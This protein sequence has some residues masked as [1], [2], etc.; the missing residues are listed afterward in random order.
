MLLA[1][2]FGVSRKGVS[3]AGHAPI[4][5]S[6]LRGTRSG[7]SASIADG[8]ASKP[9]PSILPVVRPG[10]SSVFAGVM[11]AVVDQVPPIPSNAAVAGRTRLRKHRQHRSRAAAVA[12][13]REAGV[14][15]GASP[16]AVSIRAVV[17]LEGASVTVEDHVEPEEVPQ[18]D[19]FPPR[20]KKEDTAVTARLKKTK[21]CYFFERGKCASESCCYAHSME[22][23]RVVPDLHKTKLCKAWAEEGRCDS[24]DCAFA[25]GEAELRVTDGIYKTQICHF[26]ERGR[27]LKGDRCNHAHGPGDLRAPAENRSASS[28]SQQPLQ[29]QPTSENDIA[30][31][32]AATAD[33]GIGEASSGRP[34]ASQL[35]LAELLADAG[36]LPSSKVPASSGAP[37]VEGGLAAPVVSFAAAAAAATAAAAI[38]VPDA[39]LGDLWSAPWIP[40]QADAFGL[41]IVPPL[42]AFP[43]P[44]H[45]S[46]ATSCAAEYSDHCGAV[47]ISPQWGAGSLGLAAMGDALS[48]SMGTAAGDPGAC[49]LDST[50]VSYNDPQGYGCSDPFVFEQRL[51]SLD[52]ELLALSSDMRTLTSQMQGDVRGLKQP[53]CGSR[54]EGHANLPKK[55]VGCIQG[56]E[57]GAERRIHRI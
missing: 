32:A 1:R 18:S 24:V 49:I 57:Q 31:S 4:A 26:Y 29:S 2:P 37:L 3:G 36:A 19:L 46:A 17:E 51:A 44:P 56:A 23:L 53:D 45:G 15:G 41:P 50:G 42:P 25:H 47:D 13:P 7:V 48:W 21:M 8:L 40:S 9:V 27:C 22:E 39:P 20:G 30:A 43:M 28:A 16:P 54:A 33:A 6:R 11:S 55:D 5:K 10:E 12:P 52:T 38:L 35:P 34:A 14:P